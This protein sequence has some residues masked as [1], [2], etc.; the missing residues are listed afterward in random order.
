MPPRDHLRSQSRPRRPLSRPRRRPEPSVA[1][2]EAPAPAESG[3]PPLENV[4]SEELAAA[5]EVFSEASDDDLWEEPPRE[6]EPRV[7]PPSSPAPPGELPQR[8]VVV[9]D[10][11]PDIDIEA[12]AGG[13]GSRSWVGERAARRR[14]DRHRRDAR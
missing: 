6:P 1:P 9:I 3:S 14:D 2:P 5:T 13:S 12:V 11:N 4:A 7:K 8:R 10:E